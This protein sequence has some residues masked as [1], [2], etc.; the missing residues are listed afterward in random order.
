MMRFM[1]SEVVGTLYPDARSVE[2]ARDV[3]ESA[4]P[5]LRKWV[6]HLLEHVTKNAPEPNVARAAYAQ[7]LGLKAD[8]D[9]QVRHEVE[10]SLQRL[11]D[12]GE[13]LERP[14]DTSGR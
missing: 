11:G 1:A 5:S 4:E 13:A 7:L 3:V 6:P 8:T 9:E 2:F 10:L 14:T 12:L